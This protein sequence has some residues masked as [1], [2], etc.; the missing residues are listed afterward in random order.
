MKQI[1]LKALAK[2]NL[3]L[4]VL[5]RRENGYHDVRMVMQSIY[6]YDDVKIE[7]TKTPGIEVKTNLYFL[8]V[9]ENNIAYKAAAMLIE[10]FQIEEGV[11]ITL[12]KHIPVAAGMAGGSSNAAAVL[13]G[14][15]RLFGLGLSQQQLMERGV[16]LGADVPYC[17]MRGTVLAEGIGEELTEL[18]AMPKCI[19]LVAKPP[20]SVSTK[21]VYGALDAQKIHKHPDIDGL[22]AGLENSSLP[23]IA[24]A[25][26]NVLED[27]TIPMYPVIEDIKN[28][29][30][31][32]G[33]LNAMMSGSGPTVFGLFE[34]KSKARKAQEKIR[35]K[36]L[37]KQ[38]YV[39]NI[40]SARRKEY[41]IEV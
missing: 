1:E 35:D 17:I 5:G 28:E 27:V 31:A 7:R 25:M 30:K 40:H 8:P 4:D 6:L 36:A 3:G 20:I 38:V 21:V 37:A 33:A 14:M 18:P 32:A 34:N 15:N 11:V 23:Q 22:I 41:G 13:F 12:D 24:A 9:D 29:M 16:K 19:V 26:G 10:E 2:I 39:T